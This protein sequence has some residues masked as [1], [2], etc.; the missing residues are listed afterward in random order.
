MNTL[1]FLA[2]LALL[3][4]A[5]RADEWPTEPGPALVDGQNDADWRPLFAALAAQ[6]NVFSAITEHRWFPFKKTPVVLLGE[7]RLDATRGL[8]L[9]YTHP[10]ERLMAI[11]T[12]GILLRDA[13]GRTRELASDPQTPTAN[14]ALLPIL[15]FD[16]AALT[17]TF[18][19]HAARAGE[20]WRLDFVPRD[21]ALTR[22]LGRLI[23]RGSGQTVSQLEFRR[24]A[25]QRVEVFIGETRRGVAFT[26]DELARFFR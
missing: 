2:L 10:E 7:M 14:A 12:R 17:A 6:G 22:Q 13:H 25:M 5:A 8:S 24:S 19:I 4:P 26:D 20:S 1:R 3:A 18:D 23:V 16:L 9:R 15:R 21:P 11:D